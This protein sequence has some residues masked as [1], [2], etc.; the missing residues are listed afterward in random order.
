MDIIF[1][2]KSKRLKDIPNIERTIIQEYNDG[3]GVLTLAKKYNAGQEGAIKNILKRNNIALRNP[4]EA[5]NSKICGENYS[6]SRTK[7]KDPESIAN[8]ISLYNEGISPTK[9]GAMY[10]ISHVTVKNVLVKNGAKIRDQKE[11]ANLETTKLSKE[12]S[13]I[14]KYG[15]R[16]PMQ[17]QS[18]FDKA[19]KSGFRYRSYTIRDTTFDNIQGYEPQCIEYLVEKNGINPK[20]ICAG[21]RQPTKIPTIKYTI[22]EKSHCYFPDIFIPKLNL[23]IEVKSEYT[24]GRRRKINFLKQQEARKAGYNHQIILFNNRGKYIKTI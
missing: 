16:N 17:N 2:T 14:E 12:K 22:D 19:M 15:V 13:N 5:R 21:S 23:L 8:I 4:K 7:I 9:I 6:K 24:L 1:F 11:A 20:D 3:A 10:N 18:F